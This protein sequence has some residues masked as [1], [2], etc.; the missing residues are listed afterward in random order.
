MVPLIPVSVAER[1]A[2]ALESSAEP[3]AF[4]AI[5]REHGAFVWRLSLSLGVAEADA[6]D[7]CQE[8][9]VIVHRRLSTFEGR[10]SLRTW[11]GGICY[12]VVS[13]Y[14]KKPHRRREEPVAEVPEG[15]TQA[16]Q[17]DALDDARALAWLDDTLAKLDEGKRA[18]FVLYEIEELAMND[19][20]SILGC[21][22]QTAYARLYAA[23]KHVDAAARRAEARGSRP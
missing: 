6:E 4:E 1:L 13:D 12:R 5:F 11:I 8:V 14:R 2:P 10:S 17:E 9:F 19:V 3:R 18:A 16:T 22:V 20:A 23:R 21:P 15:I 7:V